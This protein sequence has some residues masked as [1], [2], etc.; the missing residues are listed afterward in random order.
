MS[1]ASPCAVTP[2]R[3]T[4]AAASGIMPAAATTATPASNRPARRPNV[5]ASPARGCCPSR[6]AIIVST[7][8]Q[9]SAAPL[10]RAHWLRYFQLL[11]ERQRVVHVLREEH[12][13]LRDR[14]PAAVEEL[15]ADADRVCL[16]VG[17]LQ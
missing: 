11:H 8:S 13:L 10:R 5:P 2:T 6:I 12:L 1:T 3:R 4:G 15:V 14:F 7:L 17:P 16:L 9:T